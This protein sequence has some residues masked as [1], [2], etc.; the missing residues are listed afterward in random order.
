MP[1]HKGEDIQG[2]KNKKANSIEK[3]PYMYASLPK[4]PKA[5]RVEIIIRPV[6]SVKGP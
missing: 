1:K 4:L 6:V 5:S 3:L 2:E